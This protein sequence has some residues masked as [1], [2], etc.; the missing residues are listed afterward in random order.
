MPLIF[1][2]A[3]KSTNKRYFLS[4]HFHIDQALKNTSACRHFLAFCTKGL[5][6][7]KPVLQS[8][9][10]LALCKNII[11]HPYFTMHLSMPNPSIKRDVFHTSLMSGV[12]RQVLNTPSWVQFHPP[13]VAWNSI[14]NQHSQVSAGCCSLDRAVKLHVVAVCVDQ[15]TSALCGNAICFSDV[16][17]AHRSVLFLCA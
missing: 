11:Q 17:H 16:F 4:C 10:I 15:S 7:L 9:R 2:C 6:Q 14:I 12:R 8:L 3:T 1:S 5:L 13:P